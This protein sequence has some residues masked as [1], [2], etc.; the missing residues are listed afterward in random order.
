[1]SACAHREPRRVLPARATLVYP[2]PQGRRLAAMGFAVEFAGLPLH[3]APQ[4]LVARQRYPQLAT[5]VV[6]D[7]TQQVAPPEPAIH[8]REVQ[9]RQVLEPPAA[10]GVCANLG[11][12][13]VDQVTAR[14]RLLQAQRMRDPRRVAADASGSQTGRAVA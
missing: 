11:P 6:P 9:S 2:R 13:Q 8:G 1:M 3:L 4:A 10:R 14:L 5:A 7:E 12:V